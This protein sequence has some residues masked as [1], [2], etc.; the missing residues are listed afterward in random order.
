MD[1]STVVQSVTR[2]KMALATALL[3]FSAGLAFVTVPGMTQFDEKEGVPFDE[4]QVLAACEG[5]L[6]SEMESDKEVLA[7]AVQAYEECIENERAVLLAQNGRAGESAGGYT[8]PRCEFLN[9]SPIT[10]DQA[11][12]GPT[13][14]FINYGPLSFS[15]N[16]LWTVE[17]GGRVQA[18]PG[19]RSAMLYERTV[20]TV[21]TVASE[22]GG[23][24]ATIRAMVG[25]TVPP[26]VT[27]R[28]TSE[29]SNVSGSGHWLLEADASDN[30]GVVGVQFVV[31]DGVMPGLEQ[32]VPPFRARISMD[33][34]IPGNHLI[35]AVARDAAGNVTRSPGVLVTRRQPPDT[36]PPAVSVTA[37]ASGTTFASGQINFSSQA[38]DNVEVVGVQFQV[39]GISVGG[40]VMAA[41]YTL[42]VARSHFSTGDRVVTAVAR[43][44]AGNRTVSA[45]I[46][47]RVLPPDLTPPV[48]SITAPATGLIVGGQTTAIQVSAN[49]SDN[50]GVV[51][52]Q[53]KHNDRNLG[54][55]I[56]VPSP[57]Y[58][59]TL[60]LGFL[61]SGTHTLVAVA[62]DAAGNTATSAVITIT[63]DTTAPTVSIRTPA[64]RTMIT[65]ASL[66]IAVTT[67]DNT[68]VDS[69]RLRVDGIATGAAVGRPFA[70]TWSVPANIPDRPHRLTV[71]A[72]DPAQNCM[73][74]APVFV[75]PRPPANV[76]VVND[77][78][79]KV[80]RL[81]GAPFARGFMLKSAQAASGGQLCYS[82]TDS[83]FRMT[84][85]IWWDAGG[86]CSGAFTPFV[87]DP[88]THNTTQDWPADYYISYP[89]GNSPGPSQVLDQAFTLTRNVFESDEGVILYVDAGLPHNSCVWSTS[90]PGCMKGNN[91]YDCDQGRCEPM[92]YAWQT[93]T[94]ASVFPTTGVFP[95]GYMRYIVKP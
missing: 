47:V 83:L 14:L 71:L 16:F 88:N 85:N 2:T 60:Q 69:V 19:G 49:A 41:P 89:S 93:S 54:N 64:D 24:R 21:V 4:K 67:A 73:E 18:G 66:P 87:D 5:L 23:C 20:N 59:A 12:T 95:S 22:D 90:K 79:T 33:N 31:D 52:V 61:P 42:T 86:N 70:V 58:A 38:S 56:L 68:R 92:V 76:A 63:K 9:T 77:G 26:I 75:R 10:F 74:S 55:E 82:T 17:N 39:D 37:P 15:G 29:E 28:A 78:V 25:D 32:T 94:W 45:P 46:V 30:V 6:P 11:E 80:K 8:G 65:S 34:F 36:T 13:E 53:F 72:C 7:Q 84:T 48:V 50:V 81:F 91:K 43:D 40:E 44:A 51:G 1:T 3:A 62:R 27:V 57:S 35:T